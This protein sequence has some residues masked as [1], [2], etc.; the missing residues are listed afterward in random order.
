MTTPL[1]SVIVTTKNSE[2]TIDRCLRCIA[3]QTYP[4]IEII[5]VDNNSS[6]NTKKIAHKYCQ[7]VYDI[8]PERS[9]QR[10]LG[11][12]VA[13]GDYILYLDSDQYIHKHTLITCFLCSKYIDMI[14]IPEINYPFTL[15]NKAINYEKKITSHKRDKALP[16]FFKKDVFKTIGLFNEDRTFDE[17]V[18]LFIRAREKGFITGKINVPLLH[19]ES[20]NIWEMIKKYSYYGSQSSLN[21]NM[22]YNKEIKKYYSL[23]AQFFK[24]CIYFA[25]KNPVLF[26][27]GMTMKTFKYSSFFINMCLKRGTVAYYKK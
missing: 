26:F 3:N 24:N 6:D 22:K 13:K 21:K 8:G 18:E 4:N 14:C 12:R 2:R 15:L 20:I 10:N 23:D 7:L 27:F 17:D 9:A 11:I 25:V 16:R 5:V 1:I 19:D